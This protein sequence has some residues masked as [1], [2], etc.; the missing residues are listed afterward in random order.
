[1]PYGL[2]AWFV[3]TT[4]FIFGTSIGSFLNV[5]IW[6][7][8]RGES[9]V[10]PPS[11]CPSCNARLTLIDLFP[12]LSYLFLRGKCRHCGAKISSRYFWIE[13]LI[14]LW[15]LLIFWYVGV[16]Q[17][18]WIRT[19]GMLAFTTTL[20]AIFFIDL[21]HYEIPHELSLFAIFVGLGTD[22][23]ALVA[24]EGSALRLWHV[25]GV[26]IPGSVFG[27]FA[28][29]VLFA[30]IFIVSNIIYS[31]RMADEEDETPAPAPGGSKIMAALEWVLFVP[32]AWIMVI[33]DLIRAAI[34]KKKPE[35]LDDDT[36]AFGFGDVMLAAAI[37]ANL[38]LLRSGVGFFLALLIGTLVSLGLM[39]GKRKGLKSQVPF[40]PF[41][42]AGAFLAIFFTSQIVNWYLTVSGLK[43]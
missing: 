43:P 7:M 22:I 9:I 21:E 10:E 15:W 5:I 11:H 16:Q 35:E 8:P 42:V 27:L 12:L 3:Y 37:G 36:P 30:L 18:M 33:V 24:G 29:H 19:A 32:F 17:G 34:R 23:W 2:P 40:G 41:L 25:H 6:R 13:L 38:G 39:A 26:P 14:G 4:V 28:G 1:M 20:I 31:R